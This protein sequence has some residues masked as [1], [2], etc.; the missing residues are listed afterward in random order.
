MAFVRVGD[1]SLETFTKEFPAVLEGGPFPSWL[2]AVAGAL[3]SAP[4][5]SLTTTFKL[6]PGKYLLMCALN[7]QPGPQDDEM[8][9]DAPA[10]FALGMARPVT[11]EG[12]SDEVSSPDGGEVVAKDYTFDVTGLKAGRNRIVFRNAG[13]EQ[14]H[15][16]DLSEF[17]AGVTEQQALDAFKKLLMTPE[18]QPPP[19]GLPLPETVGFSGVYSPGLGGTWDIT[20]KSGTTYL[21]ACFIQDRT[22]G[23]PHAIGKNMLKTFTVQ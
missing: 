15:F 7:D 2:T 3:E 22:G 21:L 11:V 13:P 1:T 17:P 6:P 19:A 5:R 16:G 18:D 12:E 23:P 4:G 8:G 10:H 14:V 9:S 20:L